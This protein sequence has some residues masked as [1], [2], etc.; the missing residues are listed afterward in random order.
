MMDLAEADLVGVDPGVVLDMGSDWV[1]VTGLEI[2]GG[3]L[4]PAEA[5]HVQVVVDIVVGRP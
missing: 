1:Q 3:T 2:Q 5:F 4:D